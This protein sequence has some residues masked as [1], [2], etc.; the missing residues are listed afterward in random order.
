MAPRGA[1]V[2]ASPSY[3]FVRRDYEAN[4]NRRAGRQAGA[5]DHVLSQADMRGGAMLQVV[6]ECPQASHGWYSKC[7]LQKPIS[8]SNYAIINLFTENAISDSF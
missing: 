2:R 1:V 5:Q 4:W 3:A 6:S 8:M 7:N